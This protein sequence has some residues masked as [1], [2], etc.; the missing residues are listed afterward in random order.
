MNFRHWTAVPARSSSRLPLSRY[1]LCAKLRSA[2][3]SVP[4]Q[5]S[6]VMIMPGEPKPT[7]CGVLDWDRASWGD[8]HSTGRSSWQACDRAPKETPSERHTGR[9]PRPAALCAGTCITRRATSGPLG[10]SDTG[11]YARPYRQP[12]TTC[13]RCSTTSGRNHRPDIKT[14]AGNRADVPRPCQNG[15]E[16]DEVAEQGV[17]GQAW[18]DRLGRLDQ[19]LPC[20]LNRSIMLHGLGLVGCRGGHG[21]PAWR[22]TRTMM[23]AAWAG[24]SAMGSAQGHQYFRSRRCRAGRRC[25]RTGPWLRVRGCGHAGT[26]S[27][28]PGSRTLGS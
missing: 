1:R 12:T 14:M 13:D 9:R 2:G 6:S 3:R 18:M 10:S 28:C 15:Q 27:H 26:G 4:R 7:I 8:P 23:E 20:R 16:L 21:V 17:G 22:S 19:Q 24:C 5:P 11:W 25:S